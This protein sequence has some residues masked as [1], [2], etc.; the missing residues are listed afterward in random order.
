MFNYLYEERGEIKYAKN[1]RGTPLQNKC[2][3]FC[4]LNLFSLFSVLWRKCWMCRPW[5]ICH[6]SVSVEAGTSVLL[7]DAV[8]LICLLKLSGGRCTW[9]A[10]TLLQH[11]GICGLYPLVVILFCFDDLKAKLLIKVNGWL[12]ADLHMTVERKGRN[13]ACGRTVCCKSNNGMNWSV[14]M[15]GLKFDQFQ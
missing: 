15:L 14:F 3:I 10:Q 1:Q 8:P 13:L 9:T 4:T 11:M 5:G 2:S 7:P 12:I 6:S